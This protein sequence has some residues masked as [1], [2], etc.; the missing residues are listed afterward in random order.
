[1]PFND[2]KREYIIE[3]MYPKRPLMNFLWNDEYIAVIN[4]FGFGKGRYSAENNFQ[5]ELVRD[6]DSRIIY[7]KD[8][9]TVFS[10]NRNYNREEFD[11]FKTVV[12]MG[13]SKIISEYRGIH[14]ELTIIVPTKGKRECWKLEISNVSGIDK[15]IDLYA[16][17]D[18]D[19]QFS[20]HL[21][22]TYGDFNSELNGI[23]FRHRVYN[24]PTEY[25]CGY[26]AANESVSSYDTAKRRFTGVYGNLQYPDG[27]KGEKLACT[28]NSFDAGT[29]AALH[30]KLKLTPDEH[31]EIYF[32]AGAE[33]NLEDS[34]KSASEV[35]SK[36][37]FDK[38]MQ[39]ICEQSGK[40]D[41]KICIDTPDDEINR[42]V[43]IWLKRQ[44]DLGKTWGRV[45]NK[46]FRDIMQDI[47]GFVQL[48]SE[49][50]KTKI[51]D[52][53][54]YQ[55]ASGNTLRS[56]VPLDKRP[57]R[58]GAVWLLQ[59][60]CAY[61]KETADYDILDAVIPY[62][63]DDA[64]ET[65][66]AHCIRGIDFLYDNV[67]EHG[68]CL[69]GGGDWND[70]FDGAGLLLKGESVWLSIATVKAT[71][72]FAELLN[73]LNN[74]NLADKYLKKRDVLTQNI[75][76]YGWDKDHYIYGIND[77]G[78]RVGSYDTQEG[79]MFLNPQTWAVIAGI[80]KSDD[81]L[82]NFVEQELKCDFGYVQ[83][84]P[85]YKTPNPHL[86]RISYFGNGFYENGSVYNHGVAFK[87]VA[88]CIAGRGD[89]AYKTIKMMMPSNPKNDYRK[90]GVEPY[91]L[92][93]MYFGPEN[94]T[95]SG[96]APMYW[97]TGTS[98]WT[99][100][101]IVEYLIGV[102]AEYDGLKIEPYIPSEWEYAGITR[103]FRDAMY[104]INIKRAGER[105]I[106]VDGKTLDTNIVP[107]FS[108][109]KVHCVNVTL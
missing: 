101:G 62:Y 32:A 26:F 6:A 105:T 50:S 19:I 22:C 16:Y 84:K 27:I 38:E 43:N 11:V 99:F 29:M 82:L 51:L 68:L 33:K 78:E 92:C 25:C 61:I 10:P 5:H 1:M 44:M 17:N 69:W 83:Q 72:D 45:Y 86:G 8:G 47:S 104:K 12:G 102:R 9:D 107:A 93:N 60:V 35:L 30:F 3:D 48:D 95:R 56:W 87:I 20:E 53:T 7:I 52:C 21:S 39:F 13:Y 58:D 34:I 46:G 31:K 80:A 28:D 76:N 42:Y 40:Y 57:Y 2:E 79:Q 109:G 55:L 85:C 41:D 67:G 59:T 89:S 63:D 81:K 18:I 106:E 70:S 65:L 75:K 91:A 77:W 23:Y 103:E 74:T 71:N 94:A 100:R 97:I 66:L 64:K 108:D 36:Q 15:N 88:D 49:I 90:S 98:S 73:K 4:Q 37:S 24:S 96:E 14:T 54:Q